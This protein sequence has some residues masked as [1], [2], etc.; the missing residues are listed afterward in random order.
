M[1]LKFKYIFV[2]FLNTVLAYVVFLIVFR[3]FNSVILALI[4]ANICGI[5]FSFTANRYLIWKSGNLG[6]LFKFFSI[7][8]L[9]LVVNWI[10][11]HLVSLTTIP[12]ELAQVFISIFQA[13]GFY[14]L[15]KNYV[16]KSNL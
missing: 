4:L 12:R 11:L 8:I 10:I 5:I 2:G 7:Q 9:S 13:I 3:S 15:N 16:F 1:R 6:S 14:F